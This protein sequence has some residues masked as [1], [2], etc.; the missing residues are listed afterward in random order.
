MLL[1][2]LACSGLVP[3]PSSTLVARAPPPRTGNPMLADFS[4]NRQWYP[5]AFAKV[6]D[7]SL[8]HRVELLGEPIVLWHDHRAGAWRA[9]SDA[10]PHRLAPLSEGR[11][12]E[13][14]ISSK[15]VTKS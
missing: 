10:C 12:D 11:V 3:L 4:W 7:S 1:P 8:P 14:R 5:M 2:L 15:P 9:M 13:R 6:T